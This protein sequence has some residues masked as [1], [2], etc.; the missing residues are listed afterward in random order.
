MVQKLSFTPTKDY[1][2]F[3]VCPKICVPFCD[4]TQSGSKLSDLFFNNI[5]MYV[6]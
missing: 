4:C 6:G 5:D 1:P 2:N 3:K